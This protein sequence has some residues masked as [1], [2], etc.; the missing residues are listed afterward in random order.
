MVNERIIDLK[1]MIKA[2][3]NHR[4]ELRDDYRKHREELEMLEGEL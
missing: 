2:N 4:R 3:L 1:K